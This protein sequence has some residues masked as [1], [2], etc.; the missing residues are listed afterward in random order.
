MKAPAALFEIVVMVGDKVG[1]YAFVTQHGDKTIVERLKRS[2]MAM[3]EIQPTVV[4]IS[5]RRHAGQAADKVIVEPSAMR[6]QS[7]KIGQHCW[8]SSV[9]GKLTANHARHIRL[10]TKN[11]YR[12]KKVCVLASIYCVGRTHD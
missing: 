1:I 5:T 2:P 8:I 9:L 4:K 12:Q 7:R 10:S 3:K 6:I 11:V